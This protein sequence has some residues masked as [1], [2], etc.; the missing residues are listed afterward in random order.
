MPPTARALFIAFLSLGL[1]GFGGP[2]AHVG[3]MEESLVR[4]K[5][6]V[7]RDDFMAAYATVQLL[8]GPTSTELALVLGRQLLG[9]RGFWLAALGFIGPA[10]LLT[11]LLAVGWGSLH[12]SALDW[13]IRDGLAPA[14]VALLLVTS[15]RLGRG[16][17][18]ATWQL[19]VAGV[20][21]GVATAW[22]LM[23][24]D[25]MVMTFVSGV[26]E[27]L[28]QV[29]M[30]LGGVFWFFLGLGAVI[31]GSGYALVP[32]L[33]LL[34]H[35]WLAWLTPQDTLDAVAAGHLTPGPLFATATFAGYRMMG[36]VGALVATV[37]MFI[38]AFGYAAAAD[39]LGRWLNAQ[40]WRRVVRDGVAA[41][42]VGLIAAACVPFAITLSPRGVAVSV[43]GIIVLTRVT[44]SA[45]LAFVSLVAMGATL[46]R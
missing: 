20:V 9:W 44:K 22:A 1:G 16:L 36:H 27:Q 21:G 18:A 34:A 33:G 3:L 17:A 39:W 10:V 46:G 35:D 15:V 14:V 28:P 45:T 43:V 23:P 2:A 30:S 42:S 25:P 31:I 11:W 26:F 19:A 13:R 38:P 37:G 8:P 40:R 41:A 6:W 32:W 4:R 12:A 24:E 29:P 5:Q 7:S